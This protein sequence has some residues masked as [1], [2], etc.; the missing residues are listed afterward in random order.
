MPRPNVPRP[1][2]GYPPPRP[3]PGREVPWWTSQTTVSSNPLRSTNPSRSSGSAIVGGRSSG[4]AI[5]G[6][7]R[8]P[9]HP[10]PEQAPRPVDPP[11]P[12]LCRR[13]R[14]TDDEWQEPVDSALSLQDVYSSDMDDGLHR[15]VRPSVFLAPSLTYDDHENTTAGAHYHHNWDMPLPHR[16]FDWKDIFPPPETFAT[17]SLRS[18]NS[19][20]HPSSHG[21]LPKWRSRRALRL[22]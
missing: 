10:A 6:A 4:S 12:A 13:R 7:P 9:I 3:E 22:G 11:L 2:S 5:V 8:A 21:R 19:A 16:I 20:R 14:T 15:V 1:P 18:D 17:A